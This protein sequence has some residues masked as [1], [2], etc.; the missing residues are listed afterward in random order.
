[1]LAEH[2]RAQHIVPPV[3]AAAAADVVAATPDADVVDD[4]PEEL[5]EFAAAGDITGAAGRNAGAAPTALAGGLPPEDPS[6]VVHLPRDLGLLVHPLPARHWRSLQQC[7]QL[8]YRL[9]GLLM[10]QELLVQVHPPR[11]GVKAGLSL[12]LYVHVACASRQ[13]SALRLQDCRA[14]PAKL[15][16]QPARS[17]VCECITLVLMPCCAATARSLSTEAAPSVLQL[18]PA[19]TAS[20]AGEP[21]DSERLEFLG[22]AVLK[23][24]ACASLLAAAPQVGASWDLLALSPCSG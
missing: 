11:W 10:A 6:S 12:P 5:A 8:T 18:L 19:M 9:E 23:W 7:W 4:L 15:A 3:V 22:D 14:P 24:G 1:V 17:P 21:F 2:F 13:R 16:M 20:S